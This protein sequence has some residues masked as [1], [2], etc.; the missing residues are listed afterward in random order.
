MLANT[1]RTAF[2]LSGK[3]IQADYDS[4]DY[5]HCPEVGQTNDSQL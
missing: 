5:K 3:R 4:A 1:N 2:M